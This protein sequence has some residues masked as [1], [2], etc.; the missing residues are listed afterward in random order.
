MKLAM[1]KRLWKLPDGFPSR[2]LNVVYW[3]TSQDIIAVERQKPEDSNRLVS[4]H[5]SSNLFH[6]SYDPTLAAITIRT[7]SRGVFKLEA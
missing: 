1:A 5:D 6:R 3:C 2:L 4:I 7:S